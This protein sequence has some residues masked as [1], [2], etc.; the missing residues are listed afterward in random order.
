MTW[1]ESDGKEQKE[2]RPLQGSQLKAEFILRIVGSDLGRIWKMSL[3]GCGRLSI[4]RKRQV[5]NRNM[6]LDVY[7]FRSI[8]NC[9]EGI[10]PAYLCMIKSDSFYLY[11]GRLRYSVTLP[12]C[13]CFVIILNFF[14][15][16]GHWCVAGSMRWHYSVLVALLLVFLL[17]SD[18]ASKCTS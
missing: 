12:G 13:I 15:P 7:Y 8:K 18:L 9:I 5:F 3:V 16:L 17:S 11:W 6:L 14:C 4:F 1:Q 2:L 10:E